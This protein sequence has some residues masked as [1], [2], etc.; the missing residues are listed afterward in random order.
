MVSRSPR[1]SASAFTILEIVLALAIIA[2]FGTVLIGASAR[3]LKGRATS[4]DEVFWKAC[5][6]AR[7]GALRS[8]GDVRRS[9]DDKTE[10]FAVGNSAAT[11]TFP[12]PAADR[13]LEISFLAALFPTANASVL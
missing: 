2:L 5:Q 12:V 1:R 10:A 8:N 9:Y 11:Q 4:P 7:K 3:L 6:A 13:D